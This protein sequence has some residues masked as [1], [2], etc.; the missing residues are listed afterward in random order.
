MASAMN[1][2]AGEH[3]WDSERV[4][5]LRRSQCFTRLWLEVRMLVRG[6]NGVDCGGADEVD[7]VEAGWN[8]H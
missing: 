5:I 8:W 6:I 3:R 4:Q 7:G 1:F 2:K